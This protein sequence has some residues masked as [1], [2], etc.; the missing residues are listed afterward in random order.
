MDGTPTPPTP[1]LAPTPPH[2]QHAYD[3]FGT[4]RR[5]LPPIVPVTFAIVLVAVVIGILAYVNRAKP[6]AQGTID[7]IFFSQPSG[8]P[9]PM[10][11]IAV[12]LHNT[13]DKVLYIKSLSAAVEIDQGSLA[14]DAAAARDYDRYLTAYPD[15]QGHGRPLAVEMRIAPGAEQKGTILIWPPL[16]NALFDARRDTTVTIQPYDQRPIVLHEKSTPAK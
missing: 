16:T 4:P 7:G 12:T 5:N 14:D 6:A 15:L 10:V 13:S 11:L 9:S 8:M 2:R 3:E 1:P